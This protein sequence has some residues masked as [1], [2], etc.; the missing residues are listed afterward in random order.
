M[1]SASPPSYLKTSSL[2]ALSSPK[3]TRKRKVVGRSDSIHPMGVATA[4]TGTAVARRAY[5]PEECVEGGSL[6]EK[7]VLS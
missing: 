1:L 7:S 5:S 2:L 6:L 4:G 3:N